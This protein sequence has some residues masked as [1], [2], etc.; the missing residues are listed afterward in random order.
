LAAIDARDVP[1]LG[2]AGSALDAACESCHLT[3]W[4]PKQVLPRWNPK[5]TIMHSL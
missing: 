2:Q 5:A 3:Y 1:R 4:Y